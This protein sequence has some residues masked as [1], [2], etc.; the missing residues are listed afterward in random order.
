MR[1]AFLGRGTRDKERGMR[2][3]AG[4]QKSRAQLRSEVVQDQD[5]TPLKVSRNQALPLWR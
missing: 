3:G 5:F 2:G 4:G 1:S